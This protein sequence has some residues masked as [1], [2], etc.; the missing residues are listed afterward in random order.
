MQIRV[1]NKKLVIANEGKPQFASEVMDI[2][3]FTAGCCSRLGV[4]VPRFVP[5][6]VVA[7]DFEFVHDVFDF[8][9]EGFRVALRAA[10]PS[11]WWCP[12]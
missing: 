5:A 1:V 12:G 11:L 10:R 3:K 8:V 6:E 7:T 4:H 9:L 2:R